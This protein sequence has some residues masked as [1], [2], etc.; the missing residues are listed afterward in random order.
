ME[1]MDE[2]KQ[3]NWPND[4]IHDS[5]RVVV[6]VEVNFESA[7]QDVVDLLEDVWG[8]AHSR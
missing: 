8:L 2:S 7:R 5:P 3:I 1:L 6:Y 4:I